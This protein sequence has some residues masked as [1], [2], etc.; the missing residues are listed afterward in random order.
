MSTS[1]RVIISP[2]SLSPEALRGVVED[3]VTREGTDY[4]VQEYSLDAKCAAVMRQLQ[5]GDA[6]I[7]FDTETESVSVIG[8]DEAKDIDVPD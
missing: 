1:P 7:V 3:F 8:R 2:Q 6:L 4:G 5:R